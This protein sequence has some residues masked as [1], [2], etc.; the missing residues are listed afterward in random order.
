MKLISISGLDGSGKSTQIELLQKHLES[1]GKR[2]LYFHAIQFSLAKKLQ[3][4][5]NRYCLICKLSGKCQISN[6]G[7]K[8]VTQANWLQIQLRKIFLLIDIFRFRHAYTQDY[9]H[10]YDYILSDRYFFD[11]VININYLSKSGSV[12]FA[13]KFIPLPEKSLYLEVEPAMIMQ[14]KRIPDQGIDYLR[15]KRD[16]FEN[17]LSRWNLEKI[18]GNRTEEEIFTEIKSLLGI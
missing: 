11:S 15:T 13:E 17:S 6:A 16:L 7:E 1:Q 2:I 18:D 14:R 10:K 3:E 12:L 4:F 9:I 5:K 8:S